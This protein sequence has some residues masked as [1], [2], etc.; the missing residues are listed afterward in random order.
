MTSPTVFEA[1]VDTRAEARRSFLLVFSCTLIGAAA[2][3]LVKQGT[4][5][6]GAHITLGQVALHPGLFVSFCLG[7]ITN[8][9]LFIGYVCYGVNTLLMALA[10]KGRE[11]SRLYPIIALTYVWVTFLSIFLLP[12]EHL[13]F[14]RAIGIAFIVGGV[15]ILGVKK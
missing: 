6:L 7:V 10:L 11:L 2:Q 5:Q 12:D 1:T 14:F 4:T 9:K 13:N 3:I 8:L 15:S